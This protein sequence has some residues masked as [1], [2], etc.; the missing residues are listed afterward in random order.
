[1]SRTPARLPY[2][3]ALLTE[4]DGIETQIVD[5]IQRSQINYVNRTDTAAGYSLSAPPTTAGHRVTTSCK[6]PHGGAL[7]AQGLATQVRAAV[8]PIRRRKSPVRR[9]HLLLHSRDP[10]SPLV[11]ITGDLILQTKLAAVRMFFLD[12]S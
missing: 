11:A 2:I 5:V 12:P 8:P 3:K 9:L 1:M 7:R 6:L 4:L 10:G